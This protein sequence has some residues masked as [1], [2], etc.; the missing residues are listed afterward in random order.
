MRDARCEMRE[1]PR[2]TDTPRGSSRISHLASRICRSGRRADLPL[3]VLRPLEVLLDLR[4]RLADQGLQAG[5]LRL[6][7]ELAQLVEDHLV[8]VHLVVDVRLVERRALARPA[9]G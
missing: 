2:E 9:E 4:G 3:D 5:V 6:G 1:L 8:V 7:L